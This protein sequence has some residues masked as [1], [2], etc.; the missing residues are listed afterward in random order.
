[1]IMD[2]N[3][4]F[5]KK[6]NKSSSFGHEKGAEVIKKV[7]EFAKELKIPFITLFAFSTE[8]WAR[9]KNEV[10]FLSQLL[11]KFLTSQKEHF[12][13]NQI[14]FRV[15]GNT[16]PYSSSIKNK[17]T[18][19]EEETSIFTDC[20]LTIALNYGGI[21]DVIQATNKALKLGIK[22]IDKLEFTKLLYGN[23]LPEIDLLIRTGG[24]QRISNF[25]LWHIAYSELYFTD[26]LWPEFDK[27]DFQKA[28]DFFNSQKRNFGY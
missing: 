23:D 15:I 26:V 8:N 9:D 12:I 3:R 4:R 21:E 19:L 25:M 6:H 28:I 11:E 2:G 18:N 13:K 14:R 24:M 16:E 20:N 7:C 17:I 1:M 10:S 5:A 22:E 27:E